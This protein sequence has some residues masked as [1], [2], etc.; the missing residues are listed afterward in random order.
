MGIPDFLDHHNAGDWSGDQDGSS[1]AAKKKSYVEHLA[2][3]FAAKPDIEQAY[4][5]LLYQEGQEKGDL[6]LAVEHSGDGKEIEKMA[7]IV[8]S[9]YMPERKLLFAS[10]T[11]KPELLDII[12]ESNFPFYVKNKA[13]LL[14]IAIMK[15]WI[16]PERYTRDFLLQIQTGRVTSLFKDFD[17][18]SNVFSF[19]TYVKEGRAFIPLFSDRQMVYKSGMTE[20]PSDLTILEFDWVKIQEAIDG[21]FRRHLYVLNPGTSFEVEFT[22]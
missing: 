5:G 10:S 18:L 6:F 8:R 9:T 12:A 20:V 7:E 19:Q 2:R 22:L 11:I 1:S 21:K 4:F 3:V 16:D 13:S 17:P 15:Q 14:N